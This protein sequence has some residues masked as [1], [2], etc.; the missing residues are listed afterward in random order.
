M[1]LICYLNAFNE[2]IGISFRYRAPVMPWERTGTQVAYASHCNPF[3]GVMPGFDINNL[4]PVAG[5]VAETDNVW[6]GWIVSLMGQRIAVQSLS[7][8]YRRRVRFGYTALLSGPDVLCVW[9]TRSS[10]PT[11]LPSGGAS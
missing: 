8:R 10:P 5:I 11:R 6:H 9:S 1:S 4:A 2:V 3:D 7:C